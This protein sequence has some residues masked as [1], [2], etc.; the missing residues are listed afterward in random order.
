MFLMLTG[1]CW[2]YFTDWSNITPDLPTDW[3][4]RGSK[5]TKQEA[6]R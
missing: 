2:C 6:T 4:V 3:F 5:C 1:S